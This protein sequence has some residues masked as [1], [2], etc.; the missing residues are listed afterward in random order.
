M[1]AP[2][3]GRV[4]VRACVVACV[5]VCV[6]VC[7]CVF[8]FFFACVCAWC[9]CV[10]VCVCVFAFFFACVCVWCACVC[11]CVCVCVYGC[12]CG[13]LRVFVRY[14][15]S[16]RM[17][18][19]TRLRWAALLAACSGRRGA[20][21]GRG[22]AVKRLRVRM[23]LEAPSESTPSCTARS[24]RELPHGYFLIYRCTKMLARTRSHAHMQQTLSFCAR[25]AQTRE[26]ATH[27][28]S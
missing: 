26:R 7:V 13:C 2:S 28:L 11:V 27:R 8:A 15:A 10:C 16:M 9:V 19:N 21:V 14:G 23:S 1:T 22:A 3:R 20:H 5:R 12:G 6:C 18:R 25:Q 4:S 17:E 24:A